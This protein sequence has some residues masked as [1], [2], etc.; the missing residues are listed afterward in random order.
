HFITYRNNLN[1]ILTTPY[2][3][4]KWEMEVFK[5]GGVIHLEVVALDRNRGKMDR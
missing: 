3:K 2:S 4:Q 1:K 5:E